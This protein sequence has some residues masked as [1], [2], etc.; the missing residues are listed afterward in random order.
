MP[1]WATTDWAYLRFHGGRARPRPCYGETALGTWADRVVDDWGTTASGFAYFNND[2]AGCA[3]RDA[4]VFGR[5][6]I[7]AGVTVAHPPRIVGDVLDPMACRVA[8]REP[9]PPG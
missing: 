2:H 9:Q 6:L 1:A 7:H 5:K 8:R 3:L 4:A